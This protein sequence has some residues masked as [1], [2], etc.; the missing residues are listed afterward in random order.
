M[1]LLS[2][3]R[4]EARHHGNRQEIVHHQCGFSRLEETTFCSC[5]AAEYQRVFKLETFFHSLENGVC[6]C[7]SFRGNGVNIED[8][9]LF[10]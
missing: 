6:L 8:L 2:L 9:A 5:C 4:K 3:T 10:I 7:R 1:L